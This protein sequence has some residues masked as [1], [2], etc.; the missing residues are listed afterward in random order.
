[1]MTPI[2]VRLREL[3]EERGLTQ[4]ALGDLAG[5]RQA[6]ISELESGKR[7]R[8]DLSVLDRLCKALGVEVA[9]MLEREPAKRRR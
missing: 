7:Q 6:A 8:V 3:R 2:V 4:Q 5:V 1:M 9:E